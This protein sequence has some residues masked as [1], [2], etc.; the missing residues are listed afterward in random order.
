MT[1]PA[2]DDYAKEDVALDLV[3]SRKGDAFVRALDLLGWMIVPQPGS[4][5]RRWPMGRPG[6]C[7]SWA[8]P[9]GPPSGRRCGWSMAA[10]MIRPRRRPGIRRHVEPPAA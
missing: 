9:V 6:A 1:N 2:D 3:L 7:P 5:P 10:R 4:A 8:E